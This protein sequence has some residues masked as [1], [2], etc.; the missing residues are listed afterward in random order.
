[1]KVTSL[2]DLEG[3]ILNGFVQSV[4]MLD[5]E[6]SGG[7]RL[8]RLVCRLNDGSE[9]T[10]ECY[11]YARLSRIYLLFVSYRNKNLASKL[12]SEAVMSG[13]TYDLE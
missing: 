12:E 13:I 6:S 1:M 8:S 5:C 3:L 2:L 9:V 7:V 10:T 4:E 11:E